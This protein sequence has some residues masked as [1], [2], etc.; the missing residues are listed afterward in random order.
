MLFLASLEGGGGS[1]AMEDFLADP[2]PASILRRLGEGW[3]QYG[4]T[5]LRLVDK[6]SAFRVRL[7]SHLASA[8]AERLGFETV[9]DPA[10]VVEAW[11]QKRPG[12]TVGVMA[13]GAV[14]PST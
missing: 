11:R 12:A 13:S 5:T 1:D 8:L 7:H 4:H 3:V 10:A 2:R 14:Y 6:T 9:P